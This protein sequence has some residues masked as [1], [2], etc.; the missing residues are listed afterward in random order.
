MALKRAASWRI[1]S[2]VNRFHLRTK[3]Q[4]AGD[5]LVKIEIGA[6]DRNRRGAL[7]LRRFNS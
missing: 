7:G 6:K 4:Q 1:S 5:V 3:R 2:T